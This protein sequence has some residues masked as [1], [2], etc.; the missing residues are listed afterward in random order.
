MVALAHHAHLQRGERPRVGDAGD[1]PWA[2]EAYR[3][4]G[5]HSVNAAVRRRLP[6]TCS[7]A[8]PRG[9]SMSRRT[10]A[11]DRRFR[12]A[13]FAL[14]TPSECRSARADSARWPRKNYRGSR[15]VDK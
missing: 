14:A 13:Y 6:G 5:S 8:K 10:S 11:H 7:K 3:G 15:G 4:R 2:C 1:S 12:D 9:G